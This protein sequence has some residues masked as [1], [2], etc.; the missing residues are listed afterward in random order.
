MASNGATRIQ[1]ATAA[2]KTT[3]PLTAMQKHK[4]ALAS[5]VGPEVAQRILTLLDPN[6]IGQ[7]SRSIGGMYTEAIKDEEVRRQ[8]HSTLDA[9]YPRA[10]PPMRDTMWHSTNFETKKIWIGVPGSTPS[11]DK[12]MHKRQWAVEREKSDRKAQSLQKVAEL[13]ARLNREAHLRNGTTDESAPVTWKAFAVAEDDRITAARAANTYE[14]IKKRMVEA[15]ANKHNIS[16]PIYTTTFKLQGAKK[17]VVSM[18]TRAADFLPPHLRARI[19]KE[20]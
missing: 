3:I 17:E 7:Y 14:A 8:V 9:I 2:S 11:K 5:L 12:P 13:A 20:P 16:E 4:Q 19:R 1:A 10:I 15:G 18:S 6:H